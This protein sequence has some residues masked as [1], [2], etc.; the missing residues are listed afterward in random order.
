MRKLVTSGGIAMTS[1]KSAESPEGPHIL[2]G[3]VIS[4]MF[5]LGCGCLLVWFACL[6]ETRSFW[7]DSGG[8]PILLRDLVLNFY[9]PLLV[10]SITGMIALT[11]TAV[12]ITR[13]PRGFRLFKRLMLASCWLLVIASMTISLRNN[14]GNLWNGRPLNYKPQLARPE[15]GH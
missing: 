1:D 6:R 12:V 3:F 9:Y 14:I 2:T 5:L 10:V 4:S 8:Y 7:L 15:A 13:I 11:T